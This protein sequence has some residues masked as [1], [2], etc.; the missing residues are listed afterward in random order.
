MKIFLFLSLTCLFFSCADE[1]Q[2]DLV[3]VWQ[4]D[5]LKIHMPSFKN[6]DS[7]NNFIVTGKDWEAKTQTRNIQTHYNSDGTYHSV[8][9]NLKDSIVYDPAGTWKIEND[10]LIIQDTIPKRVTYKFKIKMSESFVEFWGVEDFDGDGKVD[11]E[12]YSK[13]VKIK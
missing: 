4:I 5:E 7:A 12:Y 6:S 11:D 13:Q 10:T 1:K 9:K 2:S 8:H 3:G